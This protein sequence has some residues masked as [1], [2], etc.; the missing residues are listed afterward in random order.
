MQRRLLLF[1]PAEIKGE[2]KHDSSLYVH[3]EITPKEERTADASRQQTN[4]EEKLARNKFRPK[5]GKY[6]ANADQGSGA[7]TLKGAVIHLLLARIRI[8]LIQL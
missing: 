2:K 1:T 3:Q 6:L 8:E 4:K 5:A 7:T